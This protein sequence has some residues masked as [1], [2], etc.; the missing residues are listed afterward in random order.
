M[1]DVRSLS[2]CSFRNGFGPG[3]RFP[4]PA[5][6]LRV[7][8]WCFLRQAPYPLSV[9]IV[10]LGIRSFPGGGILFRF[11]EQSGLVGR[12]PIRAQTYGNRPL[13]A[14]VCG[15]FPRRGKRVRG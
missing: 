13:P 1:A 8:V 5:G 2:C 3:R 9:R 12:H 7:S 11:F 14:A 4:F 6:G 10:R 15:L